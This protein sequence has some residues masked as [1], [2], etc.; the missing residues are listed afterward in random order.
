MNNRENTEWRPAPAGQRGSGKLILL[1]VLAVAII[2]AVLAFPIKDYFLAVLEWTRDLGAWAPVLVAA[3]YIVA[4][5]LFLPGSILTLSSG[6]LFGLWV[7]M[8]TVWIGANLGACAAFLLGRTIAREWV[9]KKVSGNAHFSAIDEAVGQEGFKIVALLR[10]SPIIPF[11][12]LNYALGLT[13]VSFPQYALATL[14]GMIPAGILYVYLGTA[15]RDLTEI[16]AGEV[17]GSTEQQ[18]FLYVGLAVTVVAVTVVTRIAARSLREVKAFAKPN[19]GFAQSRDLLTEPD[20]DGNVEILPSDDHNRQLVANVRPPNWV[21]PSPA[22]RY[23]L[24]V[25][26]AGTAGLVTAAG[27]A[28]LGAKVALVERHLLGGDCLNVGCVPSK[29]IIRS[30]RVVGEIRSARRYG[31]FVPPG[32]EADFPKVME[33]MRTIRASISTHDSAERFRNLGVD[34]FL[35]RGRFTGPDTVEVAGK[36][37]RFKKAVIA[38]GAGA[39]HPSLK[40]LAEAGFLTNETVFSLTHRPERLAVIG[41]GPIGCEMAQAFQRLGSQVVLFHR[42]SHI[43]DREDPDAAAIVQRQF[44]EDP[45]KI[46]AFGFA[47]YVSRF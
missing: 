45:M 20:M 30:S 5:V 40:G 43:L 7:G 10:L 33:R 11:N 35:G 3:F 6:Y 32:V 41:G 17:K 18:I 25:I 8:L 24:V 46:F 37:L 13:K 16:A 4:C 34:V 22:A 42:G 38:T 29:C 9:A 39:V 12:F 2:I 26:G 28:G 36:T 47:R 19:G 1:V 15:A 31:I 23:N 44:I 27:A 14:I 21:N